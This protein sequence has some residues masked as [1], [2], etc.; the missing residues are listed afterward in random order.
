MKTKHY[1]LV[2]ETFRLDL[3]WVEKALKAFFKFSQLFDDKIET[4][5]NQNIILSADNNS[6]TFQFEKAI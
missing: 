2:I 5:Q 3:H 1:V 4:I 6:Q